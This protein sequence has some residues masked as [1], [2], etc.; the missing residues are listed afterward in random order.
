MNLKWFDKLS[1]YYTLL[2][3]WG[4]RY[5]C[6]ICGYH[7]KDLAPV[8]I[9]LPV[10][11]EKRIIGAGLRNGGCYKCGATDRTKLV[12][13]YLKKEL[14][15]FK[16]PE[17]KVLHVAPEILIVKKFKDFK[18]KNYI[19]GDFF[20]EGQ[21][22]LEYDNSVQHMDIQEIPYPNNS[23]DLIICNHVLEHVKCAHKALSEIFRVLKRRGVAILQ[24]PISETLL[25]TIE[26]NSVTSEKQR[27]ELYGQRDHV[28]LFGQ[29]YP[30]LLSTHGF[31]VQRINL[32]NK[33]PSYGF[34]PKEDLFIC[35]KD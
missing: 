22:N 7:S 27:E 32:H 23:F 34:N 9:D 4:F 6:P 26:D 2:K 13:T 28:R 3:H 8:G 25:T 17:K 24:V 35:S 10:I 18:F 29:D 1:P 20:A 11:R 19:Q 31:V 21:Y 33:Y 16:N 5:K 30:H 15:V 14:K 12:Y